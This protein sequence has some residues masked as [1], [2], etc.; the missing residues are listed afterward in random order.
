[1]GIQIDIKGFMELAIPS[2]PRQFNSENN[3]FEIYFNC[4]HTKSARTF[5]PS[6][7]TPFGLAEPVRNH[8]GS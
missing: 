5:F 4:K 7:E 1:M 8:V 6:V 3:Y 2:T